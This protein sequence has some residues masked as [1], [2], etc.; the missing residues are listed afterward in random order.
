MA[1]RAGAT[2]ANLE[3]VQFHP[4][5]LYNPG[6]WVPGL[7]TAPQAGKTFLVSEAVRG[8]GGVLKLTDGTPFMEKVHPLGDLA[9]RDIVA[10]AIDYEMKRRGDICVL[11]DIS[12]KDPG[13]IKERFPN[14]YSTCKQFGFDMTQGPLPVVPAAHYFCGGVKTDLEGR[15]DLKGLYAIGET[16]CTGLHGANR[17]ASNSLLEAVAVAEYA[18]RALIKEIGSLDGLKLDIPEWDP[19]KASESDEAVV[20]T[21]NWDEIRRF[22]WNYVG[23]VRSTKRLL[24]AKSRIQLLKEEIQQYYWNVKVNRDLIELRNIATV[25]ELIIESALKRKES[26]GLH[27]NI[28]FPEALDLERHDTLLQK[29]FA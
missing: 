12:H 7:K 15:S 21:Q 9:P 14:I 29:K 8:E 16:A 20:I 2:V 22:M 17:L 4:T 28:D 18:S 27:Y 19:G 25:A 26:R 10:R 6:G 11:L 24:R 3:F 23:I 5:C 13:F 1:Y